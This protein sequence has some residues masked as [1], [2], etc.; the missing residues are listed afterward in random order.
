MK[1]QNLDTKGTSKMQKYKMIKSTR[2][3]KKYQTKQDRTKNQ[4]SLY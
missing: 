2:K 1:M 3:K 4:R